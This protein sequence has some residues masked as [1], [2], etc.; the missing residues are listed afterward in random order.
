MLFWIHR[1]GEWS[2][3]GFIDVDI[4]QLSS[5]DTQFGENCFK[6]IHSFQFL[7]TFS[8]F[9]SWFD[10]PVL[11]S[12]VN[13]GSNYSYHE[14]I[15]AIPLDAEQWII[16]NKLYNKTSTMELTIKDYPHLKRIVIGNNCFK[17]IQVLEIENLSE[18]ESITI[19]SNSFTG[20]DGSCRI[21]NCPKLN[22]IQIKHDSFVSYHSLEMN[23]LPSLH[24]IS[25]DDRCFYMSSSL[26]LSGW[27]DLRM[28][29]NRSSWT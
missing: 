14:V 15:D 3:N 5:E 25:M 19:G 18:L 13:Q 4:P 9:L 7:S 11:E 16:E 8:P 12:V 1:I 22:S 28:I 20:N 10:A 6:L 2:V 23:N 17:R 21:V 27:I 29:M 26:L 24:S